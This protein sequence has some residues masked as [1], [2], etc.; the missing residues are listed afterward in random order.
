MLGYEGYVAGIGGVLC[1]MSTETVNIS[2][3][4]L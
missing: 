1:P 3:L 2:K 4:M